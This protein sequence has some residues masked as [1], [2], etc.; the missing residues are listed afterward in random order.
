MNEII[1]KERI[2]FKHLLATTY[3]N[4]ELNQHSFIFTCLSALI[5]IQ[6]PIKHGAANAFKKKTIGSQKLNLWQLENQTF[7]AVITTYCLGYFQEILKFPRVD[8][9]LANF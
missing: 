4:I 9:H 2:V 6:I 7:V 3:S 1:K 5:H 8:F